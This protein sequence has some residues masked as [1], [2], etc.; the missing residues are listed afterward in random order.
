MLS[1]SQS[2]EDHVLKSKR[3][4]DAELKMSV[5]AVD[6]EACFGDIPGRQQKL[7]ADNVTT[8]SLKECGHWV[9]A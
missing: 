6:G 1:P 2:T 5:L 3:M 7:V 4:I 8:V 9:T